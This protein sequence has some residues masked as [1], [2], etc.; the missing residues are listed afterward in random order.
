MLGI[1]ENMTNENE[2]KT[3]NATQIARKDILDKY[4]IK[5]V[6]QD[7]YY[8]DGFKYSNLEDAVAQVKRARIP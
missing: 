3:E 4:G 6:P 1:W 8:V 7:F 2:F 5:C